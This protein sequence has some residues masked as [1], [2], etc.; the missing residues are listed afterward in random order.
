M[1]R[2][3]ICSAPRKENGSS[4]SNNPNSQMAF[5]GEFSKATLDV[6]VAACVI[7]SWNFSSLVGGIR[8]FLA[9]VNLRSTY[10]CQHTV[11]FLH[12][13]WVLCLQND[14]STW[15]SIVPIVLGGSAGPKLVLIPFVTA[16][17]CLFI[18]FFL[19]LNLLLGTQGR[20]RKLKL[21][22]KQEVRDREGVGVCPWEGS[23]WVSF[24]WYFSFVFDTRSKGNRRNNE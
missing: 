11:N 5:K 9:P 16:F 14:S 23:C 15:L 19:W 2:E 22:Y 13:A 10:W 4:C 8:V 7:S 12:L 17:L 21:F 20:S 24:W 18:F 1:D 6:R 3:F